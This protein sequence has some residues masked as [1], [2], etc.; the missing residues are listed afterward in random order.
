MKFIVASIAIFFLLNLIIFEILKQYFNIKISAFICIF[1]FFCSS[2]FFLTLNLNFSSNFIEILARKFSVFMMGANFLLFFFCLIFY[3]LNLS[4]ERVEFDPQRRE[5]LKNCINFGLII[6]FFSTLFKSFFNA[7]K[8]PKVKTTEIFIRNL[9]E[10]V[11]FCVISDLHI[12][13][14]IDKKFVHNLVNKILSEKFDALLI[15]GDM[16]DIKAGDIG[17]LLDDF[18]RIEQ[19]KFFVTGN[20]EYYRDALELINALESRNFRVL[21]NENEVFKNINL[22][23]LNDI[24][25]PQFGYEVN[26]KKALKETLPELPKIVLVHQPKFVRDYAEDDLADLFICGHTHAGQIFPFSILAKIANGYLYG[27]YKEKNRQIY[28]SSGAG[29]WGPPIRFLAP[30]EIAILNLRR[31]I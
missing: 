22:I 13:N 14:F 17:D 4:L 11:S 7:I 28:V 26:F 2:I 21:Q 9:K 1:C 20:H 6:L 31:K 16:F 12:G 25:A 19:P 18:D 30:S 15:V 8:T 5:I 29:F 27:L 23:G 3:I 10:Q 24:A